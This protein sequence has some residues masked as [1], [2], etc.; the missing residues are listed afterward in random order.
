MEAH[1]G[2]RQRQRQRA[3]AGCLR[4]LRQ[5]CQHQALAGAGVAVIGGTAH[6]V[7]QTRQCGQHGKGITAPGQAGDGVQRGLLHGGGRW[8]QHT[9]LH[10]C[11]HHQ[12]RKGQADQIGA[13]RRDALLHVLIREHPL[14]WVTQTVPVIAAARQAA[15][16]R[17]GGQQCP[18]AVRAQTGD[19][20]RLL[21]TV[22]AVLQQHGGGDARQVRRF[23]ARGLGLQP[24][25]QR[26]HQQ[27]IARCGDPV[28]LFGQRTG[29][30]ARVV[31]GKALRL[32]FGPLRPG[33][34]ARLIHQPRSAFE[35]G[36]LAAQP[37]RQAGA[38][39]KV[40]VHRQGLVD[41]QQAHRKAVVL[42]VAS[43]D[44]DQGGGLVV[45]RI[46]KHDERG[47]T[48][49]PGVQV[50]LVL[51]RIS[52]IHRRSALLPGHQAARVPGVTGGRPLQGAAPPRPRLQ[53]GTHQPCLARKGKR[54]VVAQ[55]VAPRQAAR[56]FICCA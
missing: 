8:G 39:H 55:H 14:Q 25:H 41:D 24:V 36:Q 42:G 38:G 12:A 5:Q 22:R 4:C 50:R 51:G 53:A 33:Q 29:P 43:Q 35:A 6:P 31:A 28:E 49:A 18:V 46:F 26:L 23:A 48:R 37:H 17:G 2:H 44:R 1:V 47:R 27:R 21:D 3:D 40:Q 11:F 13:Q 9:V 30:A 45:V 7:A 56:K 10:W 52:Q 19:G 32:E 15:H 54:C 20:Q 34:V 16:Q